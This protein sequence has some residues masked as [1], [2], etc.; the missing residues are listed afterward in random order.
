[1]QSLHWGGVPVHLHHEPARAEWH[2]GVLPHTPQMLGVMESIP[3]HSGNSLLH[4]ARVVPELSWAGLRALCNV[5]VSCHHHYA[6]THC[7]GVHSLMP[8][9]GCFLIVTDLTCLHSGFHWRYEPTRWDG[10][11]LVVIEEQQVRDLVF[12][13]VH[14]LYILLKTTLACIN[15]PIAKVLRTQYSS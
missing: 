15:I 10:M 4:C 6:H 11:N 1:M 14:Y 5:V 9:L 8:D 2:L 7:K 12:A 3:F 13:Q